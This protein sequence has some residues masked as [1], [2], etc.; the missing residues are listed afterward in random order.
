MPERYDGNL[1]E[2]KDAVAACGLDGEWKL[3][4]VAYYYSY[5]AKTGEIV[6]W[7]PKK[8][9]NKALQFQG[10]NQN[11]FRS[12]L[13]AEIEKR[14]KFRPRPASNAERKN[15]SKKRMLKKQEIAAEKQKQMEKELGKE[16]ADKL[17]KAAQNPNSEDN[18]NKKQ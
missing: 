18:K 4:D 14:R 6:N 12:A 7:W 13:M 11:E 8:K 1:E 15:A 5:R 9:K 3:S 2:L 17:L 16:S 10:R